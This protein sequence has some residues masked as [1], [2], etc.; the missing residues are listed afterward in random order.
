MPQTENDKSEKEDE[1]ISPSVQRA[2][3]LLRHIA[4]GDPI[5]NMAQAARK[6]G[7]NRTTL[8]RILKT[9]ESEKL[10]EPRGEENQ[11]WRIGLGL[12]G[13][14]AQAFLASDIVQIAVP[15]LTRLA[16][17]LQLSTHLALLDGGEIVYM[18]RRTPDL[19]FA[20]NIRIG[21]RLPAHATNIGRI[22]L[23][24]LPPDEVVQMYATDSSTANGSQTLVDLKALLAELAEDRAKGLAWSDGQYE[25]GISSVAAAIIDATGSPIAAINVSGQTSSLKGANRR[26]EVGH[27]TAEAAKEISRFLFLTGHTRLSDF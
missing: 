23:A 24:Y 27:A 11:G 8:L 1:Y 22:I 19:P 15:V 26:Q 4:E 21:S 3:R 10:I 17:N 6:L 13:L 16:K 18:V 9:L 12:I 25:V 20:S 7:I 14:A 2:V 5:I